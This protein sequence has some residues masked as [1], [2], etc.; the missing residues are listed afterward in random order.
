MTRQVEGF[1][2]YVTTAAVAQPP[3]PDGR[4][5]ALYDYLPYAIAF[6]CTG[7]RHRSVVIA[8]QL[9]Q[10]FRRLGYRTAVHHRDVDRAG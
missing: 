9:A 6:G 10:R 5:G 7:G 8:E 4:I 2:R 1:R 3:D